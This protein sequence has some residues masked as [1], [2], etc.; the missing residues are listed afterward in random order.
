LDVSGASAG[1]TCRRILAGFLFFA[2]LY[3]LLYFLLS[4]FLLP[5]ALFPTTFILLFFSLYFS[6]FFFL[7]RHLALMKDLF[8][9]QTPFLH[10]TTNMTAVS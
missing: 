10:G 5:A 3:F 9:L 7:A 2:P 8:S 6:L 1:L 4:F